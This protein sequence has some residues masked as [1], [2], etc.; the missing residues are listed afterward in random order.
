MIENK[1]DYYG[2]PSPYPMEALTAMKF[3]E[4]YIFIVGG[5]EQRRPKLD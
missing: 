2:E 3:K 5:I 4:R 1:W